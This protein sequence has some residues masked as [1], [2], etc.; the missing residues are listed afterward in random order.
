MYETDMHNIYNIIV[1]QTNKHDRNGSWDY[2]YIGTVDPSWFLV[3]L[4][5]VRQYL[6]VEAIHSI[7]AG[8]KLQPQAA[9]YNETII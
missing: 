9:L 3:T 2:Q 1:G 6:H 4:F 8:E 7:I 5:G